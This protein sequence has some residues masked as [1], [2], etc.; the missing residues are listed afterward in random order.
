MIWEINHVV[1]A[2]QVV[3]GRPLLLRLEPTNPHCSIRI[4]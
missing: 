1:E 2:D 3:A 4:V